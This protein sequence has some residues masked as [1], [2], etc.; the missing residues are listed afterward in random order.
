MNVEET[1]KM[2]RIGEMLR[3]DTESIKLFKNTKGYNW[4][5]K[6]LST[7]IERLKEL[8]DKMLNEFGSV[9]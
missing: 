1:E 8:N 4:E 3:T 7:D 2:M 9:E 5:V 6:I